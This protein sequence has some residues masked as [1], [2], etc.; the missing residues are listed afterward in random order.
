MSGGKGLGGEYA[1]IWYAGSLLQFEKKL[2]VSSSM[3][4]ASPAGYPACDTEY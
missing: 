2:L 4:P 1:G 3:I